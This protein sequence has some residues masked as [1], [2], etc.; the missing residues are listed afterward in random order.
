[1]ASVRVRYALAVVAAGWAVHVAGCATAIKTASEPV[2]SA[3]PE[4]RA[5]TVD[6]INDVCPI[7][8]FAVDPHGPVALYRNV[9]VGFCSPSCVR[10]WMM[11]TEKEKRQR[12]GNVT[13]NPRMKNWGRIPRD[14]FR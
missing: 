7:T 14:P 11:L 12:I 9:A 2:A 4:R 5:R 8:G 3:R 13:L 1:M 10:P 6:T